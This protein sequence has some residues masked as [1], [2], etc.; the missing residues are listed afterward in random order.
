MEKLKKIGKVLGFGRLYHYFRPIPAP[1][2]YKPDPVAATNAARWQAGKKLKVALCFSGQIRNLDKGYQHILKNILE[3]NQQ[4]CDMDVFAHIWFSRED[5]G[6]KF[7]A[8]SGVLVDSAVTATALMDVYKYYNPQKILVEKPVDFDEQDYGKRKAQFIIP[9][10]SLRKNYS[11]KK[12]MEL[13]KEHELENNFT[14]DFVLSLRFDLGFNRPL[15]FRNFNP[16]IVSVSEFGMSDQ[17]RG[18][19]VTN[20]VIGGELADIYG[21]FYNFIDQYYRE[22]E[23]FCDEPMFHRHLEYHNIPFKRLAAMN[24]FTLLRN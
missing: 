4:D 11:I 20:A 23:V 18:V 5:V 1:P 14:Y 12:V 17:G 21:Q 22:G 7:V 2:R 19:D 24:D 13:K 6:K 15:L 16:D 9:L 10:Y 8:A 3:P